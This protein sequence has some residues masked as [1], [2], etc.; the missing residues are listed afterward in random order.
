MFSG[1]RRQ[2]VGCDVLV[3]LGE[4][5][6]PPGSQPIKERRTVRGIADIHRVARSLSERVAGPVEVR[7]ERVDPAGIG[8]LVELHE[9]PPLVPE[10]L[11]IFKVNAETQR[12][13]SR[14]DRSGPP[15]A[16]DASSRTA[17]E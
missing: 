8:E 13:G 14:I 2:G 6:T 12:E 17:T 7:E 11:S 4:L 3:G 5:T 10:A 9:L 16:Y 15:A 1:P